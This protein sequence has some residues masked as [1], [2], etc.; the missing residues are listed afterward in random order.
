MEKGDSL[1]IPARLWQVVSIGLSTSFGLG[2]APIAPGTVGA[3]PAVGAF[4]IVASLVPAGSQGFVL[5]V[6]FLGTCCL[7]APLGN[8]A[9]R[10]W[11]KKDPGYFVL[12]EVAGFFLTVLLFRC[13]PVL[14]NAV[15]A[16][17]A[18]RFFDVV[19]PPPGRS[20]E[21]LPGGWGILLDDLMSSVYAAA[22]LH[23][24][25]WALPELFSGL[26]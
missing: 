25:A 12:D 14:V 23:L 13:D 15:A 6:L 18:A 19:K 17:V 2:Y 11:G 5:F 1:S 8:W 9:E 22:F 3:L 20:L 16:F 24:V 21:N 7:A 4:I 10:H 26:P